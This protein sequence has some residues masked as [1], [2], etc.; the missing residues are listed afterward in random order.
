MRPR[1]FWFITSI[2]LCHL[3]VRAQTLTNALPP[4]Q[5][6]SSS[7]D[8]SSSSALPNDP[9]QEM[10]PLAVPEASASTR[11]PVSFKADRQTWAN[12]VATLYGVEEFHYRDY[13]ISADKV[14]YHQDTTELEAEGHV[15]VAG[16]PSDLVL[17]ASHGDMR[18]DTHTARFYDVNGTLGVRARGHSIV[19][20]TASPFIFSGRVLIQN[21]EGNYRI[22]DGSM[23]N[24][25]LPRPDW[26]LFTRNIAVAN[27]EASTRNTYFKVFG[28]PVFYLPY[29]RHPVDAEGRESGFL[30][31]VISNGSSI[32]GYTFGE[33]VYWVIN[34]SADMVVGTEYYS[35]RGWAPNGDF[36]YKGPGLDHVTARWNALLDRG[37]AQLQ[38]SGPQ[39]G[40]TI[41]VNQGG[42]DI[43]VSGRKDLSDETR[44]AGNIEYLSSYVY[45]LVFN[46]NYWQ[47]VSSEVKSDASYT[48]AH[49]G[50][51]PSVDVARLQNF[52]GSMEGNEVRILHLPSLRYDVLDHPLG[53]TRFYGGLGSSLGLLARAEPG[54]H[55][56]SDGR[57]DVYPH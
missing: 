34:R 16:G 22:V 54:F 42:T 27:G 3:L 46:D 45:R 49:N 28:F 20:S 17:T 2:V 51:V 56:R 39:S 5:Q 38:T 23:T 21:G 12:K 41:L 43:V 40:Q 18:L 57:I 30:I 13:V 36:R 37:I 50:F 29:L 14:V 15:R 47:A 32:R 53:S 31:P 44:I 9:S 4:A 26:Q 8:F 33:Q 10:L 24:C 48:H 7:Q 25:R 35:K 11:V 52:A 55:A 1:T 19:Y 6:S